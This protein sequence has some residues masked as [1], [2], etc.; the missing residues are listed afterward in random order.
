MTEDEVKKM[1]F[2]QLWI[3]AYKAYLA[4]CEKHGI[5]KRK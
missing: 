5:K 4:F 1:T 3:I 2:E